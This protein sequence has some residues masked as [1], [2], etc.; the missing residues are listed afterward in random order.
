MFEPLRVLRANQTDVLIVLPISAIHKR[1][2]DHFVLSR[3]AAYVL[4]LDKNDIFFTC[5]CLS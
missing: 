2:F 1:Y 3:R 5:E 4:K